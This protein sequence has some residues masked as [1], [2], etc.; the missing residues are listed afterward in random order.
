MVIGSRHHRN[1]SPLADARVSVF[2]DL[3]T[4]A[5]TDSISVQFQ[6]NVAPEDVQMATTGSGEIKQENSQAIIETGTDAVASADLRT[7]KSVRYRPG[8][9]GFAQFTTLFTTDNN[10]KGIEDTSQ[11]AGIFNDDNGYYLGFMDE[12]F[13]VGRRREGED[14]VVEQQNFNL[15]TL[16]G[17][18]NSDYKPNFSNMNVY[19]IRF[20]WLGS[21]PISFEILDNNGRWV[22]FHRMAIN[23]VLPSVGNP[24]LPIRLVANKVDGAENIE[25]KT[26]S[27]NGGVIGEINESA[28]RY[29]SFDNTKEDLTGNEISAVFNLRSKE[30]FFNKENLV[31]VHQL[32]MSV[33][34]DGGGKFTV[35]R[36]IRNATLVDTP[37]WQEVDEFNSVVE[38]DTQ[39]TDVEGGE[40]LL[41]FVIG[42][43]G[44]QTLDIS[45]YFVDMLGGETLSFTVEPFVGA[46]ASIS[47]RWQEEF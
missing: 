25:M 23:D 1:F 44:K 5:K 19:R 18:N 35:V 40:V 12:K 2:S 13:I 21:A 37:N 28:N 10:N 29:K 9:E 16:D 15:D 14:I 20:G 36:V 4:G 47:V 46:D 31:G 33:G 26:A 7:T 30:E 22:E 39:A 27:L 8:H 24:V 11:L 6:Y 42:A 17:G 3:I 38:Y 45:N 32:F 41:S 43:S 34:L